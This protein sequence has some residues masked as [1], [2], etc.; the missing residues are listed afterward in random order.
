MNTSARGI[1]RFAA[2]AFLPA[3]SSCGAGSAADAI[4]TDA[5]S[6]AQAT[7]AA[8]QCRTVQGVAEPLVVDWRPEQR[9]DLEVAMKDGIA[10]VKYSCSEVR[11]LDACS[12]KGTYGF[13]GIT[14]KEELIRL[15]NADE[16]RANLPTTGST[17]ALKLDAEL[18]RGT[19]LDVAL[20]MI[21]KWSATRKLA[22]QEEL[23]GDC[24]GATHFVRTA[25]VGAFTMDTGSAAKARTVVEMFGAGVGAGSEASKQV[26][27]RDG[28]LTDCKAAT[29]AAESPPSQCG[30]PLRVQL[31]AISAAGSAA[32]AGS[33][34]G[35]ALAGP[36]A[37][38]EEE[39]RG[40]TCPSGMVLAEGKCTLPKDAASYQCDGTPADC[41][42]QCAKGHAGSCTAL[43]EAQRDGKGVPPDPAKA[44]SNFEKGCNGGD[45]PGCSRYGALLLHGTGVAK[46]PEK[47]LP[48]LARA[49]D[50]GDALGCSNLGFAYASGLGVPR[51]LKKAFPLFDQA[52]KAGSA[53]GCSNLGYMFEQGEVVQ[54]DGARA[55]SLYQR[56]CEG[57][58]PGGCSNLGAAYL[59][60]LGVAKDVK[61]GT[62]LLTRACKA[63][64]AGAC[65]NLGA[66]YLSGAGVPQDSAKALELL[67]K[68]CA[69]DDPGGCNSLG[70]I[71]AEG[72]GVPKDAQKAGTFFEK[73]C[74]AGHAGGCANQGS[75][76]VK[77][78]DKARGVELLQK[79][80]KAGDAGGCSALKSLGVLR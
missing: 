76:L 41:E 5:P 63:E 75:L 57:G 58:D 42:A 51:D 35:P 15:K 62:A 10:V 33:A 46:A 26:S 59:N 78:G 17:L 18:S 37:P 11:L 56:G 27:S 55:A 64:S 74:K 16:I 32:A 67:T 45:M 69:A 7:G 30:A 61:R 47:A 40:N 2:I 22:T 70:A 54:K 20:V 43:G 49:C 72:K 79:G 25:T 6:V 14:T 68:A 39:S 65:G 60:G 73:A 48:L 31:R 36:G 19:S 71:Y 44:A 52:C 50:A 3:V 66:A 4:R 28:S 80:C 77:A 1:A 8:G 9:G 24:E 13:K 23:V 12:I 21:G 29:P 38:A 53:V 34:E